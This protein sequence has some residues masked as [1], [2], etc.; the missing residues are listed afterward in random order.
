MGKGC[1]EI[2]RQGEDLYNSQKIRKV[3]IYKVNKL[4]LSNKYMSIKTR[5][6][7]S[8]STGLI[9]FNQL[10]KCSMFLALSNNKYSRKISHSITL[11]SCGRTNVT[12]LQVTSVFDLVLFL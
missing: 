5:G 3:A 9:F 7:K 11:C 4:I 2:P 10:I 12:L 1:V 6:S 8:S